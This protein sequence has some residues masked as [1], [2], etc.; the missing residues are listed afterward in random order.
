MIRLEDTSGGAIVATINRERSRL[1]SSATGMVLTLIIVGNEETQADA[2]AAAV[3]AARS[4]PM[5]GVT[6]VPRPTDPGTRLDADISVGGQDGPGEVAVLRLRGA[7]AE[8]ANSVAVPLLLSDTPVVV[9]WPGPAPA[10][11]A[12]DPIGRHAQRRITN[13]TGAL[14]PM[15]ELLARRAGYR[16]GDTDL[17]WTRL[18][19]WRSVLAAALDQ[20]V[21]GLTS[22]HVNGEQGNPSL[23]LLTS[24]LRQRLEVPVS[25]TWNAGP[26][27]TSVEIE[28][29]EVSIS[30]AREADSVATLTRTGLPD[31]KVPL[32][33]RD[34]AAL[35]SEELRRMD[36]DE[37]YQAAI[38]NVDE[39]ECK[40]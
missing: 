39:S 35:L 17:A 32:P 30:V 21:A 34:L 14:D 12:D 1:G 20:P 25:L 6:M 29:G 37:A 27:V 36:P 2:T 9:Y 15:R 8:H 40:S 10:V 33:R 13:A 26:G 3:T 28:A 19:S 18:T 11:P 24:W 5:R 23:P 22:A 38:T 7:L 31:T 16:S 4:H